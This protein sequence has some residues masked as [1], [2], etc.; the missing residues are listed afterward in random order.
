MQ[1]ILNQAS[2]IPF[3]ST[4]LA[5]G[6]TVFTPVFLLNGVLNVPTDITYTEISGGLYTLNF[7]PTTSGSYTL[8]IGGL[9]YPF[10]VVTRDIMTVLR[11]IEDEALGS[12][13][14]NKITG[15]LSLLRQDGSALA[16]F[17]VTDNADA[18]TRERV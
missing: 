7:T 2:K 17:L 9:V 14:W 8:F 11:S 13:Q 6:L 3:T 10:E 4:A 12:W 15:S 16:S 1:L 18:A 5:T